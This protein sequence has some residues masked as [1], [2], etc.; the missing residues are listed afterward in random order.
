MLNDFI[1]YLY[2][3]NINDYLNCY[4]T[5]IMTNKDL[6]DN[7]LNHRMKLLINFYYDNNKKINKNKLIEYYLLSY[8]DNY[9][10]NNKNIISLN[11]I[12]N[13]EEKRDDDI[14]DHYKY[15]FINPLPKPTIDYDELDRIYLLKLKLEEEEKKREKEN[16][17]N[18][19]Y[20]D[21]E[22]YYDEEYYDDEYY[23]DDYDY[24]DEY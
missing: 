8:K 20:I 10:N 21:D 16:N 5:F 14:E 11:D 12:D 15:M 22:E 13:Y 9:F 3:N 24:I 6:K 18:D 19:I 17:I 2:N 23:E 7:V 1:Y 4:S